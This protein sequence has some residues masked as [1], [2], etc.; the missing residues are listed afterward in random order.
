MAHYAVLDNNNI[1]TL[2]HGGKDEG[3]TNWEEYYGAKRTSYNTKGGVYYSYRMQEID[4]HDEN[5]DPYKT[6]NEVP[7]VD[8]TGTPFRKNYAGIGFTYDEERDAFIP[9]QPYASWTLNEDTCLWDSPVPSPE[10]GMHEWN[11][12]NQEWVELSWTN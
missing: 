3:D 5:D 2:V 12:D 7:F 10:K 6:I 1:V 11:E 4:A 9:P 8:D